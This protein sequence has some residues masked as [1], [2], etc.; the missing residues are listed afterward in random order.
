MMKNKNFNLLLIDDSEEDQQ[1]IHNLLKQNPHYQYTLFTATN[2]KEGLQLF[3]KYN[4]EIECVLLDQG[5]PDIEGIDILSCL[6]EQDATIPVIILTGYG[7]YENDLY[8]LEKGAADY[9]N[10]DFITPLSLE[11]AIRYAIDKQRIINNIDLANSERNR[12][13]KIISKDMLTP[14]TSIMSS[15]SMIMND[16]SNP[17]TDQQ[18]T[19]LENIIQ[20]GENLNKLI[21]D[22]TTA[23]VL[24]EGKINLNFAEC[25]FVDILSLC[26]SIIKPKAA[27][28]SIALQ[29]EIDT[30]DVKIWGD[31]Q[32]LTEAIENLL[33]TVVKYTHE[34][35]LS[36]HLNAPNNEI[37]L[38][39]TD[40]GL[41]VNSD[42][43]SKAFNSFAQGDFAHNQMDSG[44]GIGLSITQKFIQFH[45]GT[46]H[47]KSQ[48]EDEIEFII[49][50]PKTAPT[51]HK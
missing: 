27:R 23:A 34:G 51:H 37:E 39:I 25:D 50:L 41:R 14:L 47:V 36:L 21:H 28:K 1:L 43:I 4:E 8:A 35:S 2:G 22:I 11:R 13:L 6:K 5:L 17:P 38:R 33:E 9:I 26:I 31:K 20:A 18:R 49:R 44:L 45:G 48:R 40:T 24:E 42:K 15:T 29:F 7:T 46:I 3:S 10:K 16:P 30:L 12:Y 19:A 32:K